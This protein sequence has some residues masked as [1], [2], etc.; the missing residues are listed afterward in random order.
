V[1]ASPAPAAKPR[2]G[3]MPIKMIGFLRRIFICT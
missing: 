2:S 1:S 3:G